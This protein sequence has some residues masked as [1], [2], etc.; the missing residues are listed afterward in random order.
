MVKNVHAKFPCGPL[1]IKKALAIF[2]K[3]SNNPN[4]NNNNRR[5]DL[6]PFPGPKKEKITFS[7]KPDIRF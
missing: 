2:W 5:S 6:G 7:S 1:R 4:K 3:G